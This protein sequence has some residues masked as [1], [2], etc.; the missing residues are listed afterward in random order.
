MKKINKDSKLANL[1]ENTELKINATL[2]KMLIIL[3]LEH[4]RD[5]NEKI[6]K[7]EKITKKMKKQL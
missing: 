2:M 3:T 6:M 7:N 1:K 4:F 5:K